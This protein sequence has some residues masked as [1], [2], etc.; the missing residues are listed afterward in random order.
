MQHEA[1]LD[2]ADEPLDVLRVLAWCRACVVTSAWVSPRVNSDEPCVRGS[3]PTSQ[4]MV[5]MSA[6]A[7]PSMRRAGVEHQLAQVL[8]LGRLERLLDLGVAI[9]ELRRERGDGLA[10][11]RVERGVALLLVADGHGRLD[12]LVRA[13]PPTRSTMTGSLTGGV[14]SRLG[15]PTAAR[16]FSCRSMSG[17]A[18]LCAN[19]SAS[20]S[21]SSATSAAPPSTITMASRLAATI[22]SSSEVVPLGEGRV[23]DEL[24]ADRG[25]RA[26]RRTG[27]AHGMS[28]RCSAVE[29]PVIART[30]VGFSRSVETHG[31]DRPA[32]RS[33]SP[34][35]TAAGDGRSMRREVRTSASVMR[36]SRLK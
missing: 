14:N 17:C 23:D 10:A 16:S 21:T 19:I 1:L 8:L 18:A 34:W 27:P 7:R 3:T 11:G 29:A 28:D 6:G 24:A 4:V 35:G 31:R 25:R 32:C 15:L 22:R 5:R 13:S 36:P 9:G 12:L 2:V 20:M 33:A 30:S 26:R